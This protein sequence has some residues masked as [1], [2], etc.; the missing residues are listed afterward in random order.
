MSLPLDIAD[1]PCDG[2]DVSVGR[3]CG[4]RDALHNSQDRLSGDLAVVEE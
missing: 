3:D 4:E 1:V 2:V